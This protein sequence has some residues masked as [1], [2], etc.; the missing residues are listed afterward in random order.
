V[1]SIVFRL[2]S[3]AFHRVNAFSESCDWATIAKSNLFPSDEIVRRSEEADSVDQANKTSGSGRP[4]ASSIV[5]HDP[6]STIWE[7]AKEQGV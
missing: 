2:L 1:A 3:E 4:P 6:I 7:L 5:Y